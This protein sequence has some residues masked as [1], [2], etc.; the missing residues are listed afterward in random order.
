M[1]SATLSGVRPPARRT[2]SPEGAPSASDQ[3]NTCP[4]P[5]LS[6][7]IITMSAPKRGRPGEVAVAAGE[8]LDDHR[9]PLADPA[10]VV[11]GLV[12]VELGGAEAGLVGELDHPL[13]GLVPEDRRR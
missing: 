11:V 4:E 1:A 5:G 9:H 8:R 10:G 6:E 2:R 7:S 3:S 13:A 12:A